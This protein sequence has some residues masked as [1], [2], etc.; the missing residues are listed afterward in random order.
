M[1][2]RTE[3]GGTPAPERAA[4]GA[5]EVDEA[6][7]QS[8]PGSD[9]PSFTPVSGTGAPGHPRR[10]EEPPAPAPGEER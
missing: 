4:D 2:S 1:T 6:S 9:P 5:D 8:F 7:I 3:N 10:A